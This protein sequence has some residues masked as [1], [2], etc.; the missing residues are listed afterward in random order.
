[1]AFFPAY[2]ISVVKLSSHDPNDT[3]KSTC[4]LN[5]TCGGHL[6]NS[7]DTT[8]NYALLLYRMKCL[9][10]ASPRADYETA[11]TPNRIRTTQVPRMN[12]SLLGLT[13]SW[14]SESG[15]VPSEVPLLVTLLICKATLVKK[16]KISPAGARAI[17]CPL[18]RSRRARLKVV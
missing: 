11:S 16:L 14:A 4:E 8:W 10:I 7:E 6:M 2:L 5:I 12:I 1:M 18:Q 13:I 15:F 17:F 9:R 3:K